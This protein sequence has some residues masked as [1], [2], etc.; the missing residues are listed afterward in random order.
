MICET[1]PSGMMRHSVIALGVLACVF[2][3]V[4]L[5][6]VVD[7]WRDSEESSV[8]RCEAAVAYFEAL[9]SLTSSTERVGISGTLLQHANDTLADA[10]GR[11]FETMKRECAPL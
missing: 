3:T 2:A 8:D 7:Q 6:F 11:A 10:W 4:G 9:S 1:A 5:V